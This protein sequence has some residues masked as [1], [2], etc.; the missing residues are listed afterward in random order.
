VNLSNLNSF[1]D[2]ELRDAR[3]IRQILDAVKA[4]KLYPIELF[5]IKL[6]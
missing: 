5:Q 6:S 4:D 3:V 2:E 1:K